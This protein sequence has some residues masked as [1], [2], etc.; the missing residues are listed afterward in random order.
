MEDENNTIVNLTSDDSK[1]LKWLKTAMSKGDNRYTLEHFFTSKG[2]SVACDGFRLFGVELG[3]LLPEGL[4]NTDNIPTKGMTI[5]YKF[6]PIGDDTYPDFDQ[7]INIEK[8]PQVFWINAK[9]LGDAVKL[10]GNN[11][12][13]I[14]FYD[15]ATPVE[16]QFETKD[17]KAAYCLIMPMHEPKDVSPNTDKKPKRNK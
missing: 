11:A 10:A 4:C 15:A 2:W 8:E 13:K 6:P 1:A 5:I 7:I 16:V 3:E 9:Y 17:K 12:V 14:T